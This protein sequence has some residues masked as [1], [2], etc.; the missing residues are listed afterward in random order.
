MPDMFKSIGFAV[1]LA[2]AGCFPVAA[3]VALKDFV[4]DD[5]MVG[6]A[7][8]EDQF[9]G[10][11]LKADSVTRRHFNSV[12]A[13]NVMKSAEIN[14]AKGVYDFEK[15]D[16]F[17]NYA[18]ERGLDPV[19]HVLVWHSQLAPWFPCDDNGNYVTPDEL[20]RRM[21]HHI[22]TMM[23]RYKG[24]IKTWEVVN[25]AVEGDGSYRRSPFYEILGEEYIPLAFEYARE[26]DP[27]AVLY[28]NDFAMNMP[29]KRDTYVRILND[30]KQRGLRVDAIGMQ[31]HMGMDYPDIR[32]F[33]ESIRAYAATGVN[34]MITEWDASALPTIHTGANISDKVAYNKIFNPYPAGLPAD[35]SK[36]W[37]DRMAM[38]FDL[39]RRYSDVIT[40]VTAWGVSDGY[41][42]KNDFP[43]KGRVEYPL[44]FDRDYNLKPFLREMLE[45]AAAT[46]SSFYYDVPK[47]KGAKKRP[48]GTP[49]LP[50]CYPDPSVVGVDGDYYL[51]NSTFVYYPGVPIWHSR[52]LKTWTRIG[53]VLDRPSQLDIPA[54]MRISGGIYA[55]TLAYN[56]ANKLFYMITTLVDGGGN[57]Y[58]TCEDPKKGNWSDPVW[59]PGVDG[60][61]PSILFDNDGKA[62]I[63]HNSG[64]DGPARY[65]GHRAI[66]IHDFDW[67]NNRVTGESKVLVDGGVKPEENP[68]WIE[69][70]HL[71]HIGDKYFLM[72]A[73]G[74]TSLDHR[75]VIFESDSP[76][77]PFKPCKNPV[78]L[79]Q[80]HLDSSRQSPVTSVGHADIFEGPDGKWYAVFLGIRPHR[81]NHDFMGRETFM[82]PVKWKD[83]QPVILDQ[84]EAL[85]HVSTPV[86]NARIWNADGSL[87][88]AAIM[89]RTPRRDFYS[90][91]GDNRLTLAASRTD[92]ATGASPSAIGL[93]VT[94]P[95]FSSV[96]VLDSFEPRSVDDLAGITLFHDDS[97]NVVFGKS[98]DSAGRPCV[99]L[100]ALT[101]AGLIEESTRLLDNPG[102]QLHL[103]AEGDG[104]GDL[105]FSFSTD[106][107]SS[108]TP[109]GAP[110]NGDILSTATSYCF[111]GLMTGIYATSTNL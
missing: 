10:R 91:D 37:N 84:K 101:S 30:L 108:W 31:C 15:A 83:G 99:K 79:T 27:D 16:A 94:E 66:R 71:Y 38:F 77:G 76:K 86:E 43:M 88:N 22:T 78:I 12:T 55:P 19:G 69:G 29:A 56:P 20:K 106:G 109:V 33:E 5:F 81:G 59:L 75:E 100:R 32:D 47:V 41:S 85:T 14:P 107:G 46:F 104:K 48:A 73:E 24:K 102:S 97:H 70:P 36:Q 87:D 54:G 13:E 62:Y 7:I 103:R 74:G 17:V 44:L 28:I 9:L 34:V 26:A 11:D 52:D 45:P 58:V 1:M 64:P 8:H 57:F 35:V 67:K 111:T 50:G 60:I 90:I 110:V 40:R 4:K 51:V 93:W 25:E 72:C 23:H 105:F 39:F 21:K 65:D 53:N 96:A 6:V 61:D 49:I 42:W 98:L 89:I 63:V 3:Q 68:V 95:R 82:L 80:R 92:I 2:A 18:L